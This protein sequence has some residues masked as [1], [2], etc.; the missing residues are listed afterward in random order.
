MEKDDLHQ[1]NPNIAAVADLV[2]LPGIGEN[3]AQ[4]I[5]AGQP[6]RSPE[7]ML[8]VKGLGPRSLERIRPFLI[9]TK[10]Q[11]RGASMPEIDTG[12]KS[13]GRTPSERR[14]LEQRLSGFGASLSG[15][16]PITTQVLWLAIITGALSVI[17]SVILSL[18]ILVGINRT[19]NIERHAAVRELRSEFSQMDTQLANLEAGLNSIDSRLKAVE[20]LSGRMATLE[21]EF[22][23]VQEGVDQ[24]ITEV[25]QLTEQVTAVSDEVTRISG[26]VNLFD[27]FL[28]GMRAL[29]ADLFAPVETTSS[30]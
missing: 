21:T 13:A 17:L 3:M 2:V 1:I 10:V 15:S 18:A 24:A 16:S 14:T 6:Y 9:F 25:D 11:D 20:G 7:D 8:R 29:M 27:A 5:V 28:E 26:K 19:L 23:L 30:P 12:S 22:D 4:R